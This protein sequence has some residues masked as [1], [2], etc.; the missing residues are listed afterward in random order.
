MRG[1]GDA[2]AYSLQ[3][4]DKQQQ[5]IQSAEVDA[6]GRTRRPVINKW[7]LDPIYAPH[8]EETHRDYDDVQRSREMV[9]NWQPE[10]T[11]GKQDLENAL[12]WTT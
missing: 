3:I 7:H 5:I 8:C 1:G 10:F 4:A 12:I 11:S 6:E 2:E 9:V